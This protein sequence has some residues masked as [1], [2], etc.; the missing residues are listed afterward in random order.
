[1][2]KT[3]VI[4]LI[5]FIILLAITSYYVY[6]TKRLSGLAEN[7]NKTYETYLNKEISSADL[8]SI[9]NKA[10]DDNEK[11]GVLKQKN[12]IYY[13]ENDENSIKIEITFSEEHS[14]I[15]MEAIAHQGSANFMKA[16]QTALFKCTKIE[17]HEKTN[18]IK[19]LHF[20]YTQNWFYY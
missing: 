10:L 15:P 19:Y 20:E 17:Y 7:Y 4:I 2:K 8:I 1:M 6:N 9:I 3:F 12:S 14:N 13:E 5:I 11:N 16:F 18:R